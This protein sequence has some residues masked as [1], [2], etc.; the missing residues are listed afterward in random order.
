MKPEV[1]GLVADTRMSV[2]LRELRRF[3]MEGLPVAAVAHSY[4]VEALSDPKVGK[5]PAFQRFSLVELNELHHQVAALGALLR[6]QM[7]DPSAM[8]SLG[9]NL[10]GFLQNRGL[11]MYLIEQVP[12]SVR[13]D[14]RVQR[15]L[16]LTQ[17]SNQQ[18]ARHWPLLMRVVTASGASAPGPMQVACP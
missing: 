7:G 4:H 12:A 9:A 10:L 13:Q 2:P 15:M 6:L 17:R 3:M 5:D 14:P 1:L 11:G 8:A 16:V 18:I